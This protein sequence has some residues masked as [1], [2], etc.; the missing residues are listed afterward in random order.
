MCDK[1][2]VYA[3]IRSGHGRGDQIDCCSICRANCL[4]ALSVSPGFKIIPICPYVLGQYRKHPEWS[5]VM[6]SASSP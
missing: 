2:A 1:S 5:D 4:T 6:V 3:A